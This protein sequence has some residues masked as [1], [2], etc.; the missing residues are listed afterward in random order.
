MIVIADKACDSQCSLRFDS[1]TALLF[2]LVQT[3]SMVRKEIRCMCTI[4]RTGWSATIPPDFSMSL[5]CRSARYVVNHRR[6]VYPHNTLSICMR[7]R[8]W[9]HILFEHGLEESKLLTLSMSNVQATETSPLD[10]AKIRYSSRRYGH[11]AMMH[12]NEA[13]GACGTVAA[14]YG[15]HDC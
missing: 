6:S 15:L 5:N 4:R 2:R 11:F 3:S 9:L 13:A 1:R 10:E 8:R 14:A 12:N 7:T